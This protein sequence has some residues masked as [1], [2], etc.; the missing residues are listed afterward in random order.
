MIAGDVEVFA[1]AKRD[2][3]F[4]HFLAFGIGGVAVE[5]LRDFALR[6]LPLREG[7]AEAMIGE[8]RGA[9]LLGAV[10][11]Q[12]AADVPALVRCLYA[13][14][15]FAWAN[16]ADIAEIDLNPIKVL[17][18]GHGAVVVDALIVPSPRE[19]SGC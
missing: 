18:V 16:R 3:A 8:I 10:R 1:G 15:D 7:E 5:V 13:L 14:A 17:P 9:A 4:G 11:G 19:R 6:Q 12:P 2:P